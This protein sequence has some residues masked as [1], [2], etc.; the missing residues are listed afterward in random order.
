MAELLVITTLI[1]ISASLTSCYFTEKVRVKPP[2]APNEWPC[3]LAEELTPCICTADQNYNLFMDCSNATTIDELADALNNATFPFYIFLEMTIDQENIANK[4][5]TI[6]HYA[7]GALTFE[8]INI[9]NTDIFSIDENVFSLSYETL[10]YLDLSKNALADFPFETISNYHILDSLIVSDNKFVDLPQITSSTLKTLKVDG[11]ANLRFQ[12]FVFR[13][14]PAL[15][16]ISMSSINLQSL[17]TD[18]F[19]TLANIEVINLSG[20]DL[21]ELEV[22]SF[23]PPGNPIL[24]LTLSNNMIN[25]VRPNATNGLNS[26]C[27]FYFG[28]NDVIDLEQE[29][30]QSVFDQAYEGSLDFTGNP[31]RCGCDIAWIMLDPTD[32]YRP[33]ITETTNCQSG[34]QL[35]S[36]DKNFF[37]MHCPQN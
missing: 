5:N 30:W 32:K 17:P 6:K 15:H 18:I 31:L 10:K 22:D 28:G 35:I 27:S 4:L 29:T 36:L 3:P 19:S 34:E 24:S 37:T 2:I 23:N 26:A 9:H 20:N 21:V 7:F 16:T 12:D 33:L 11:N 8:R 25:F 13:D 14:A 1:I